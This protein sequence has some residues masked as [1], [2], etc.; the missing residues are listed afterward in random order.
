MAAN[1]Y[2]HSGAPSLRGTGWG[3]SS[4]QADKL[5]AVQGA[6]WGRRLESCSFGPSSGP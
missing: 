5:G 3:D 6:P 1:G 4:R 2:K